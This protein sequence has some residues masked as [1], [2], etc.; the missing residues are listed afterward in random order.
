MGPDG[1]GCGRRAAARR[2]VME[3]LSLD[4]FII[5][6]GVH[7]GKRAQSSVPEGRGRRWERRI[8]RYLGAR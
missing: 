1:D 3:P 2:G 7:R 8:A 6:I 5:G 4:N